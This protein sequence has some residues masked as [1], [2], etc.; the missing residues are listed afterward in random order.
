M[1][2]FLVN[3]PSD[4]FYISSREIFI[5]LKTLLLQGD[6]QTNLLL[7][8]FKGQNPYD[9]DLNSPVRTLLHYSIGDHLW[10]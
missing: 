5:L 1:D 6:Q 8:I 4:C 3:C 2:F 9:H 10:Y 7:I